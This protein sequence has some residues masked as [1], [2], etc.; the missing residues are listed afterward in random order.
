M[1]KLYLVS[2]T[3]VWWEDCMVHLSPIQ[4]SMLRLQLR[5]SWETP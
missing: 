2:K 5:W 1:K 4:K 3:E